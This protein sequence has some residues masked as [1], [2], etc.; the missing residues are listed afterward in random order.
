MAL[1]ALEGV[2]M[3]EQNIQ[4]IKAPLLPHRIENRVAMVVSDRDIDITL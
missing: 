1:R 3:A 4:H 2:G